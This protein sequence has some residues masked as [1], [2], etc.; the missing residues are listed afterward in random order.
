MRRATALAFR[1]LV[2]LLT[3]V[4]RRPV[5]LNRRPGAG[6]RGRGAEGGSTASPRDTDC[7]D[8][9]P[10]RG[11]TSALGGSAV[12]EN[13]SQ[14]VDGNAAGQRPRQGQGGQRTDAA[15][16]RRPGPGAGEERRLLELVDT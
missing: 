1:H 13:R 7:R 8:R 10:R 11:L 5:S 12:T 16:G 6:E 3:R 9:G 15:D 14:L 2:G 4:T